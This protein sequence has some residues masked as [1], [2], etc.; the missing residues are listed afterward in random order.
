M[1]R[2][3]STG[4]R[5]NGITKRRITKWGILVLVGLGLLWGMNW[6]YGK[7]FYHNDLMAHSDMIELS[8]KAAED[9]LQVVYLGESS[10]KTYAYRDKDKR[11]IS[12][13]VA[14]GLP[15]LRCGDIT[16]EASHA[17]IY[18]YLL[19]NIPKEN[20]V[21]TVI[22]TM[23]LRS[24]GPYWIYSSLETALQKQLVLMKGYPP[25][26][27][28]ALLAFKAYPIRT[29]SEWNQLGDKAFKKGKLDLPSPFPFETAGEWNYDFAVKGV[30]DAE[31]NRD[32]AMT[33]LTSHFVKNYAFRI[34]ED[35]VRV[36]DFDRIVKLCEQRGWRL[37]FNL[38]AENVDKA[39][40]LVGPELVLLMRENAQ[41]LSE[42]YAAKGVTVVNN[43][44]IVRDKDFIDKNWPTEHY[45]EVGRKAIANRVSET[46]LQK[47]IH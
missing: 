15:G 18:Y 24:F 5:N 33:E 20:C 43:L 38:M 36:K 39:E 46:I 23:N 45:D 41:F 21:E 8:W 35:N 2:G 19:K 17:E 10:N 42:R 12:E 34:R 7:W 6:I 37:Y 30:K 25:L 4:L 32:Q 22:V 14:E 11:K 44:E 27:G 3:I 26:M 31:G 29:T 16:K 13:M 1:E 47:K 28:R 40:A 9:R